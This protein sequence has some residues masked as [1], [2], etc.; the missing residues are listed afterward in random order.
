MNCWRASVALFLGAL[1]ACAQ[2]EHADCVVRG[3][4]VDVQSGESLVGVRVEGPD[5][6]QAV[7]DPRGR[8]ILT[9]LRE[10]DSGV[11]RAWRSDDWKAEV[12]LRP[13]KQGGVSVVLHLSPCKDDVLSGD[14]PESP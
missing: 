11:I 4:V 13:L 6:S 2:G 14:P 5:G 12:P 3:V 7:S 9:G 8:F 1:G 10:G